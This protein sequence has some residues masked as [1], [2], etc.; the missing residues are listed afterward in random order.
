[1]SILSISELPMPSRIDKPLP[2]SESLC[3]SPP[4]QR[5]LLCQSAPSNSATA[6]MI[7]RALHIVEQRIADH[8]LAVDF[9][10]CHL[11]VSSR[12]LCR[13]FKRLTGE[14]FRT[15][16]AH[17]RLLKAASIIAAHPEHNIK[18]VISMVGYRSRS[19]FDSDFKSL[20]GCTPAH[21]Q[22]AY[23]RQAQTLGAVRHRKVEA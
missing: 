23:L 2:L 3:Y 13:S 17:L 18:S 12:H 6:A 10:A 19:H 8:G 1:M 14:S 4:Y 15:Y 9:I 21:Y 11:C 22:R 7:I 5:F 20:L 16:I